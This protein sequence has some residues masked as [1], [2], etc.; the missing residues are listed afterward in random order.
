M[1]LA[2]FFGVYGRDLNLRSLIYFFHTIFCIL[3]GY[4]RYVSAQKLEIG[5]K[6][7]AFFSKYKKIVADLQ[8][9]L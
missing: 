3:F 6:G 1:I 8:K 2:L 7:T 9:K 4:D 5:C